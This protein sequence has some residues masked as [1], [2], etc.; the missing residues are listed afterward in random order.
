[1]TSPMPMMLGEE[2][3]QSGGG[4]AKAAAARIDQLITAIDGQLTRQVNAILHHPDFQRMEARWRALHALVRQADVDGEEVMVKLL[5]VSWRTLRRDLERAMEFDQST[6]HRLVYDGEFGMP[7]GLP[8]GLIVAD[9][10]VSPMTDPRRG[11]QVEALGHIAAVGAAAFCPVILGAASDMF[12]V[13]D[14]AQISPSSD[15]TDP[16]AS[17]RAPPELSR[18]QNLRAR[19]DCRFLG[20]V[21]PRIRVRDSY[22]RYDPGRTD[23]FTFDEDRRHPCY[24]SGAFAFAST[25][26]AAFQENGWFAAIRGAYQN[27]T[28]GGRVPAFGPYD[29]GTDLHGL[30]A[31][32]PVEYRFTASQEDALIERGLI[33][34]TAFYMDPEAVF[35]ANPSL[36]KPPRYDEAVATENARLGSMLQYVLCMS[37]FAHFLKVIMRDEIGSVAEPSSIKKRLD[38]WLRDYTLGNEDASDELKAQYPLR[39]A[40]V[41]VAPIAGKP[42]TYGVTIR[43]QPHFQLDDISTSF[44]LLSEAPRDRIQTGQERTPA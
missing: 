15:L 14:F 22:S 8:F 32:A 21:A 5:D 11:D 25:I 38:E 20:I 3:T 43:L 27:A 34:L 37:R 19:E 24:A 7:G 35:N 17:G 44:H 41:D 31:Q 23:G 12:G 18:W 42:G 4:R 28:G 2:S 9:Y 13:D 30:S 6:L 10:D 29:F 1:M 33:P 40:S 16:A 36:H 26:I 39:N